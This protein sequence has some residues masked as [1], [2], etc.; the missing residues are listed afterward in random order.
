MS[1]FK[2][3]I[4]KGPSKVTCDQRSGC[5]EGGTSPSREESCPQDPVVCAWSV[6]WP[7]EAVTATVSRRQG[8][9]LGPQRKYQGRTRASTLSEAEAPAGLCGGAH[10][11]NH[12]AIWQRRCCRAGSP[13][14][15]NCATVP[16]GDM[17]NILRHLVVTAGGR[18]S[19]WVEARD[20]VQ[21]PTNHR[22]AHDRE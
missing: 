22:T 4:K 13:E 2:W 14:V 6:Q 17:F 21:H 11:E 12:L 9:C 10:W 8:R 1:Y 3:V 20:A 7:A 16:P 15:L 19:W 18:G 5:I